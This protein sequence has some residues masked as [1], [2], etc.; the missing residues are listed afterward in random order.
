MKIKK[1]SIKDSEY[2]KYSNEKK[3]FVK[4]DDECSIYI[5]MAEDFICDNMMCNYK[6]VSDIHYIYASLPRGIRIRKDKDDYL[7]IEPSE[8]K[9]PMNDTEIIKKTD[10]VKDDKLTSVNTFA[11]SYF[12]DLISNSTR[13]GLEFIDSDSFKKYRDEI[14]NQKQD[15]FNP[16]FLSPF[17]FVYMFIKECHKKGIKQFNRYNLLGNIEYFQKRHEYLPLLWNIKYQIGEHYDKSLEL[18]SACALLRYI[19]LIHPV[20]TKLTPDTL[21]ISDKIDS[22]P[23]LATGKEYYRP[24]MLKFLTNQLMELKEYDTKMKK[25][26]R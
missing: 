22:F 9:V 25:L 10:M 24:L 15:D 23:N 26:I 11:D 12:C 7:V 8:I 13:G 18:E 14:L 4:T 5:R 2:W 3:G 19:G 21:E 6:E 16:A 20:K 1:L 17:L